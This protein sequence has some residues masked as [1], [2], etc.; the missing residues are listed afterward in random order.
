[1]TFAEAVAVIKNPVTED[2]F[3]EDK[4]HAALEY[5]ANNLSE[6]KGR[7]FFVLPGGLGGND[8]P[9]WDFVKQNSKERCG[10]GNE[11]QFVPP[12]PRKEF[13]GN[14][15]PVSFGMGQKLPI[16]PNGGDKA[17]TYIL[18]EIIQ[19]DNG[20][21]MTYMA[22]P[23]GPLILTADLIG[24]LF[25]GPKGYLLQVLADNLASKPIFYTPEKTPLAQIVGV[26]VEKQTVSV[27]LDEECETFDADTEPDNAHK[28]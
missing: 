5:V 15:E 21:G 10:C 25:S 26:D 28:H 7:L 16:R 12:N 27:L 23:Y 8:D 9:K 13:K 19:G 20:P 22:D 11:R 2:V 4:Y 17:S 1:M 14:G 3:D 18:L 6:V 24:S